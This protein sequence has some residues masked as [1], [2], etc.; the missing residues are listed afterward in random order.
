MR[1]S[2]NV[3][4]F[5]VRPI[6]SRKKSNSILLGS[7]KLYFSEFELIERNKKKIKKKVIS[8]SDIEI[9]PQNVAKIVKEKIKNI[10]KPLSKASRINFKKPCIMGI[11]N[12]TPDSFY[13]GG[14][15]IS[16]DSAISQF[17]KLVKEGADIIDVGGESTRPGAKKTPIK[18]EIRR[19]I[20]ILKSIQKKNVPISLDSRKPEVIAQA[21]KVGINFVNDVSGLRYSKKTFRLLKRSN[22]PFIIMHSISDPKNMQRDIKYDDVLLDV[23]DFFESQI[24]KCKKNQINLNNIII[25]PGIGFGKTV[26]QNLKLISNISLF[27]SL[28]FP[29]LLGASRKSFIGKLSKNTLNNDRLGGSIAAVLYGS[30]QGV[31]IFRVHDVHETIQAIKIFSKI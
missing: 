11:L 25:D 27:H 2:R 4:K 21:L 5:Y 16:K 18:E 8:L 1:L 10:K 29:I 22:L 7:S 3:S 14:N 28:G 20:P 9:L 30:T 19:V 24:E 6:F 31:Q 23:Y 13:D 12:V 17:M 26:K 15:Y